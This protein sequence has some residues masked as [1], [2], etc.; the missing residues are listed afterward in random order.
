MTMYV[1]LRRH[2]LNGVW[3]EPGHEVDLPAQTGDWLV[4]QG[5]MRP[6]QTPPEPITPKLT[7]AARPV[8]A[9]VS[10]RWACCGRRPA[11]S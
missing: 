8:V 6:K 11:R 3:Q 7:K 10:P 9:V 1:L 5:A 4:T 2:K